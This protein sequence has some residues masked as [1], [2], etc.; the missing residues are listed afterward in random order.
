MEMFSL[1][2]QKKNFFP[3]EKKKKKHDS[4]KIKKG[5][6][7]IIRKMTKRKVIEMFNTIFSFPIRFRY[8][9]Q[10]IQ[11]TDLISVS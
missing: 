7:E 1:L 11:S 8:L 9:N 4:Y 5:V 6:G 10:P 3:E 2:A